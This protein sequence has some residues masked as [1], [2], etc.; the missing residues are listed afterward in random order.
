ML[1]YV[2]II[3]LSVVRY[4]IVMTE[5]DDI[6]EQSL[7]NYRLAV[8]EIIKNNTT[9]LLEDDIMSLIRKP[10]LDSM[11][12][13]KNKFLTLA[14]REDVVLNTQYLDK[15]L[16]DYREKIS[17]DFSFIK[18]CRINDLSKDVMVFVPK[19]QF[20][21]MKITKKQL[22]LVNKKINSILKEKIVEIVNIFIIDNIKDVFGDNVDDLKY[23]KI[24][25]ELIKYFK[26]VYPKEI[27]EN[28]NLKLLVK[29]TTLIN[30]VREQS[31][32]Y[33]F[34]ETNSRINDL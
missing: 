22:N 15:M 25:K 7:N 31:E 20:D 9:S 1:Y 8:K 34:T 26:S 30:G 11:D 27:L 21:T 4:V 16:E 17:K 5:L 28:I 14:K 33:I 29:D 10:P 19:K 18:E 3:L 24:N 12:V 13:I 6:K 2:I 23:S 32:R